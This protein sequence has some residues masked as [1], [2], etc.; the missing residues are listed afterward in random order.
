MK[1]IIN[2]KEYVVG[3]DFDYE[4]TSDHLGKTERFY[5]KGQNLVASEILGEKEQFMELYQRPIT[6]Y[7]IGNRLEKLI[8]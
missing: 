8:G 2:G 3:V 4:C 7:F 1:K 6:W 5:L